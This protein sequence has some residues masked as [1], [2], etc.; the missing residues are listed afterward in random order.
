MRGFHCFHD[1]CR[2][3]GAKD[4]LALVAELDGPEAGVYDS[5]SELFRDWVYDP[6]NDVAYR[7]HGEPFGNSVP[8]KLTNSCKILSDEKPSSQAFLLSAGI[9]NN[10]SITKMPA[11]AEIKSWRR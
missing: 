11:N 7:L 3:R 9:A 5:S 2:G 10:K 6:T 4:L 8:I 1:H